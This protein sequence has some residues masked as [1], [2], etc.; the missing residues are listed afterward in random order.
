MANYGT[1]AE[2]EIDL[3][4]GML[5][6]LEGTLFLGEKNQVCFTFSDGYTLPTSQSLRLTL[7]APDGVTP[8][9]D[10]S[11][12]A[13]YLELRGAALRKLFEDGRQT[14]VLYATATRYS[15][16]NGLVPDIL[17]TGLL[18]VKWSPLV[19]EP[20]GGVA[21]MKGPQGEKGDKGDALKFDDL[22]DEQKAALR[23]PQGEKGDPG[24]RG[25]QGIQGIQ[26]I[27]GPKGDKGDA[28]KFDDLTDEQKAALKGEKGE[29]G[30]TPDLSELKD[31]SLSDRA[32]QAETRRMVQK[33]LKVLQ[34]AATCA[35][36][37][38]A[39]PAF[40]GVGADT[41]WE[42]V[43]PT[44]TVKD[45][46]EGFAAPLVAEAKA[47]VEEVISEAKAEFEEV[48]RISPLPLPA[49]AAA[50]GVTFTHPSGDDQN[51]AVAV[52]KGAVAALS[53][54]DVR[55]APDGTVLRSVSVAIG[56][57]AVATN[58]AKS[59]QA[60][61]VGW[62]AQAVGNNS[63]AIGSGA[64]HPNETAETGDATV[65][66]GSTAVAIGYAAKAKAKGAWQ[67]GQGV[68]AE[69]DTLK[70][71]DVT[72]VKDG[73]VAGVLDTNE[74]ARA[75]ASA[76]EPA[77][78]AEYGGEY[79]DEI[80]VR[81]HTVTT[82][83]PTNAVG[84]GFEL[85]VKPTLSRNF[86]VFLPNTPEM[87]SGLPIWLDTEIA[88][89][90]TRLGPWW[91]NRV[92]RLPAKVRVVEPCAGILI[93]EVEEYDDG[94]DWT[95]ALAAAYVTNGTAR[96]DGTNL[97]FAA[98]CSVGGGER[99]RVPAPLYA[100]FALP[101]PYDGAT[102]GT[103]RLYGADGAEIGSAEI[104]GAEPEREWT[105]YDNTHAPLEPQPS[106]PTWDADSGTWLA[107][108]ELQ[109]FEQALP[110]FDESALVVPF[111]GDDGTVVAD[112]M[113]VAGEGA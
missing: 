16:E 45:V 92:A 89:P 39:H 42:D 70:F 69:A 82:F 29:K 65:A 96:V 113:G 109:G 60:V 87:R 88:G 27:Q 49:D 25:L 35:A 44:N 94:H 58:A 51:A 50:R 103:V 53:E 56:G 95:P 73:R 34:R 90:L 38:L 22:T 46:V 64:Q 36:L 32:T 20:S 107:P 41:A 112:R 26:G 63:I 15:S 85:A 99:V 9:A 72:I 80:A 14:L 102:N 5:A 8:V 75:A 78:A 47:E 97:H 57:N 28:L 68:N 98:W 37:A 2:I 91:T 30:D 7:F 11:S 17:A 81:S 40:G 13:T 4:T 21:T 83:S 48:S 79:G 61:A 66:S 33:I 10:N 18:P 23:G 104:G 52:G 74:V 62:N 76:L 3:S 43:P 106:A 1:G 105:W 67:L 77:T 24:P 111:R 86:E 54:G 19:F 71:R 55:N 93:A 101:A 84:P 108:P 59:A 31:V 12:Q 6:L 110:G 100:G